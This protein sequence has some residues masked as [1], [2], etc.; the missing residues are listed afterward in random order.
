MASDNF[1]RTAANPMDGNWAAC[2]GDDTGQISGNRVRVRTAGT[3]VRVRYTAG[4]WGADQYSE[5]K[6]IT[7]LNAADS[8]RIL[9]RA[10]PTEETY[11]ECQIEAGGGTNFSN[12][13]FY[14][15]YRITGT[16]TQIGASFTNY[17]SYV[18]GDRLRLTISGSSTP[19]LSVTRNDS[20]LFNRTDS[21]NHIASGNPGFGL[22]TPTTVSDNEVDDWVGGGDAT[23]PLPLVG[24]VT[25]A[26][27]AGRND[28]GL[29][30]RTAIKGT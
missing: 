15:F 25:I 30:T 9:V 16:E 4:T 6:L 13:N 7:N 28:R 19:L 10:S 21:S 18:S 5:I 12:L 20:E 23:D 22:T 8:W 14:I 26:G 24:A 27:I 2:T 1:N 29:F 11:Y 3:G 17:G